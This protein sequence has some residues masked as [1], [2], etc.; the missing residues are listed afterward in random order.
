VSWLN[1][2]DI[3]LTIMGEEV[4][5][6]VAGCD[7]PAIWPDTEEHEPMCYRHSLEREEEQEAEA[8]WDRANR[9]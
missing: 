4:L 6:S 8:R 9:S 7:A 1:S 3:M 2:R 5:C